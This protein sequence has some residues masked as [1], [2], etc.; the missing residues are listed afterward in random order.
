[1]LAPLDVS[2]YLNNA[3]RAKHVA[4]ELDTGTP[5]PDVV[6]DMPDSINGHFVS[7]DEATTSE[8]ASAWKQTMILNATQVL[9]TFTFDAATA[10]FNAR[11]R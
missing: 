6:R 11:K 10:T 2:V 4:A 1:M 5:L 3:L 9:Y 7:L 8:I